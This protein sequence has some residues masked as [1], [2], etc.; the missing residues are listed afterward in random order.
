MRRELRPH[1]VWVA[2]VE[3]GVTRSE[4]WD[5]GERAAGALLDGL[6]PQGRAIYGRSLA[7]MRDLVGRQTR[8]AIPADRVA[9]R[10]EHALTSR[11]PRPYYLIGPDA[12]LLATLDRLPARTSDRIFSRLLGL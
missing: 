1:G 11:R 6:S 8:H 4:I 12:H 7:G 10:I 3:P 9:R 5:K 2:C